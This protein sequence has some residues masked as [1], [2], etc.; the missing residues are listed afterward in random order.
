M[1]ESD[2]EYS[3]LGIS[4]AVAGKVRVYLVACFVFEGLDY[5]LDLL[6]RHKLLHVFYSYIWHLW[7]ENVPQQ[8]N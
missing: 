8:L 5:F 4:Y 2:L 7:A 1:V 3:G 6:R